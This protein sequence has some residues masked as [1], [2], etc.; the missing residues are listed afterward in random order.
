MES[1]GRKVTG[2][3]FQRRIVI[4]VRLSCPAHGT[5]FT[6]ALC[7][8]FSMPLLGCVI[9]LLAPIFLNFIFSPECPS[10]S[11]K[12]NHADILLINL[13]Y[14]SDVEIINDRTETPPPLASLNVSKL[15]SKARTEKEEKL[16][17]AYAISAGVSLEGQQLF[18][19][20]H[21]TI[22]DCK[23]QE[24]NIVVMEEVVITPPYQVENCKGKEGSAL[25]HVRKIVSKG[26]VKL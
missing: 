2:R 14:V 11:G 18:Q 1:S 13:Q 7:E 4:L 19:T 26:A 20:I 8:L 17:Q 24:K 21:K 22:K 25:S 12:P 15:A 5:P 3:D 6:Q 9:I 10:S 16:S 23:W